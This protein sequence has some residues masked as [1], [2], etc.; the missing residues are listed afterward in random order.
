MT[1]TSMRAA[2]IYCLAIWAA[3]RLLL[4]SMRRSRFDIRIIPGI[5]PIMLSAFVVA[6]AAPIVATG[7]AGTAPA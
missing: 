3:I 6:F 5:G 2:S 7:I 1:K 4:L